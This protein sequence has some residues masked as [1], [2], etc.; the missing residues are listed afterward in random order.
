MYAFKSIVILAHQQ[1][2][3]IVCFI[4]IVYMEYDK[5]N[6]HIEA[7][8][9]FKHILLFEKINR[10]KYVNVIQWQCTLGNNVIIRMA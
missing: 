7:G 10:K 9:T 6:L 1:N 2:K 5:D 4:A 3:R 8:T